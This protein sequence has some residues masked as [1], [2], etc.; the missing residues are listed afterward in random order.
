MKRFVSILLT[1]MLV[2]CALSGCYAP[3]AV[4]EDTPAPAPEP[5]GVKR[6]FGVD[7]MVIGLWGGEGAFMAAAVY[8]AGL[9][10]LTTTVVASAEEADSC[11]AVVIYR[12]EDK[13][14][15]SVPAI[16]FTGDES[17]IPDGGFGIIADDGAA[18][19]AAMDA[20]LSYDSHCT[21][22]RTVAFVKTDD[23]PAAQLVEECR[24]EGKLM[25]KGVQAGVDA[26]A[27]VELLN[28]IPVGLL[29][30]VFA[31]NE[32][33]ALMAYDAL[34]ANYRNDLV[35]VITPALSTG[36]VK[37]MMEDR[38][39]MGAAAGVDEWS[40]GAL[41][42]RMAAVLFAGREVENVTLKPV[43][44]YSKD[45]YKLEFTDDLG[46]E[47]YISGLAQDVNELYVT[48]D[49]AYLMEYYGD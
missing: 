17:L 26:E 28:S 3:A 27:A 37:R 23:G 16:A 8:Q 38:Y 4:L 24:A 32:E 6:V 9:M 29:D 14:K 18:L 2:L 33:L 11:D 19:N 45:L 49:T 7:T 12:P 1:A 22:I 35:E 39:L 13:A 5:E 42:V 20:L 46:I 31:E 43:V 36:I 47:Q 30:T 40:A 41:A 15:V 34:K 21:P 25:M 44:V 48:V 10:G